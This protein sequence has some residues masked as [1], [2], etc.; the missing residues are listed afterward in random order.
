[1]KTDEK[2][3]SKSQNDFSYSLLL[4]RVKHEIL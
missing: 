2:C 4:H 3:K 1:M